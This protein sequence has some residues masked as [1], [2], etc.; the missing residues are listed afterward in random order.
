[1]TFSPE[2]TLALSGWVARH[3]AGRPLLV[4]SDFD[5]VLAPLVDV[6]AQSRPTP[7]AAAALTRIADLPGDLVRLALVSGRDIEALAALSG[8]P[9]GTIL[10][11]SHGSERGTSN[12]S[13]PVSTSVRLS[14]EQRALLGTI[15]AELSKIADRA[16]GAWVETKPTAAV[17]H[18][19]LTTRAAGEALTHDAA[20][21]GAR[22]GA[23]TMLGKNVVEIAVLDTSKGRALLDLAAELN[24]SGVLY[25][26]DDRTDE[27]AFLALSEQDVTVKI[28]PGD[29]A[30]KYRVATPS[31]AAAVLARVADL[32]DAAQA[33]QLRPGL[34]PAPDRNVS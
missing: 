21:L 32:L 9:V 25:L 16:D 31:D 3:A 29:T 6:P 4:A 24:A 11:G 26:G 10:I 19:R 12:A 22:L 14:A 18:T 30:A 20:A 5:G 1:M 13:A 23:H 33:D 34:S 8:A 28:G 17:L 27:T 7:E 15:N 2:L